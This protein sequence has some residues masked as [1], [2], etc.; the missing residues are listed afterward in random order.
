MYVALLSRFLSALTQIVQWTIEAVDPDADGPEL[1][2]YRLRCDGAL[3]GQRGYQVYSFLD[4]SDEGAAAKWLI[5]PG[6]DVD[7]ET[8]FK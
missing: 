4:E 6:Q 7:G 3:V 1:L 5:Q 2:C 8:K